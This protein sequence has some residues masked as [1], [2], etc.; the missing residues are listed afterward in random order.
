MMKLESTLEKFTFF[1]VRDR[2]KKKIVPF[3][4]QYGDYFGYS[5]ALSEKFMVVGAVDDDYDKGSA[6]IIPLDDTETMTKIVP[7]DREIYSDFGN[8]VAISG[9][10]IAVG[11]MH[12]ENENGYDGGSVYLFTSKGDFISKFIAPDGNEYDAFGSSVALS[13]DVIVVGSYYS[14]NIQGSAYVFTIFGEFLTKLE[15]FDREPLDHFGWNVAV[16]GDNI[17]IGAYGDESYKGSAYIYNLDGAFIKKIVAPDG[18]ANYLFGMTVA[19]SDHVIAVGSPYDDNENGADA[20]SVY[21]FTTEGVFI[22]KLI[23]PDGQEGD[24][25]GSDVSISGNK[26]VVGALRDD[27]KG[28]NSGS[29]YIYLI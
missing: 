15:A 11:S 22:D 5:V 4:G 3:D 27:D 20:G 10:I 12:D 16:H 18:E 25:F 23:A 19:I 17:I 24:L 1:Q 28:L 9:D 14:S 8:T 29:A 13:K 21:L 26:L 7:P 6:F 2:L